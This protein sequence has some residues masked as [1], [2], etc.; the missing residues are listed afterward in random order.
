MS[1]TLN[2]AKLSSFKDKI[3]AKPVE[4]TVKTKVEVVNKPRKKKK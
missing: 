3:E 1:K 2:E 4:E